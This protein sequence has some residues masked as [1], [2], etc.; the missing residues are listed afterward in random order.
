ML[1][2]TLSAPLSVQLEITTRCNNKCPHCYN[3][4]RQA[5]ELDVTITSE[6][7]RKAMSELAQKSVFK[8][9]ITGGEPLLYPDLTVEAVRLANA[10]DI[11]CSI[12]S[13]LTAVTDEV[14]DK[15]D[16]AGKYSFLTSIASFDELTHDTLMGRQGAFRGTLR[17]IKLLNQRGVKFSAN[18]VVSQGNVEQVFDT[19]MF[20]KSL[21]ASAFAATKASPPMGCP[22][23]SA[24]RPSLEQ[25]KFS[26]DELLRLEEAGVC[27]DILECYPL[28]FFGDIE[29]Y[30]HFARRSCSAG[31]M[32]ATIGS[33]G[34]VR[35]CSHS[36]RVYGDV[37]TEDLS[38]IYS[39]MTE[40]RTGE[41]L[42]Q[43]CL[44]CG[45][46]KSCSG[47]CRCEA[48]YYGK[49]TD[50]DPL[51]SGPASVMPATPRSLPSRADFGKL[52]IAIAEGVCRR[53][54]SF[55]SIIHKRNKT[56]FL[57]EDATTLL[58]ALEKEP[59]SLQQVTALFPGQEDGCVNILSKL[60]SD[61]LLVFA[62]EG[63]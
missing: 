34:Q 5:D 56:V 54:E 53:V 39:R 48:E 59:L 55:G 16:E 26:L 13:N 37:F 42:P 8:V 40:W 7:L 58:D 63:R 44:S 47:G 43:T 46:L 35:P 32:S 31:I 27:V 36:N 25:I 51:A 11:E 50:M 41:L 9:T 61:K 28:C 62:R 18:M 14:L 10:A 1:Y 38:V 60:V 49:V 24:I 29:K 23:Y 4:W 15:L 21:G 19:G 57:G 3:F 17:G 20:A 52:P 12:N 2:R 6:D 30:R 33:N 22:D 45:Y